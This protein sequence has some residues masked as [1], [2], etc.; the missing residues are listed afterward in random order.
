M[1]F[2]PDGEVINYDR[3][4]NERSHATFTLNNGVILYV[5]NRGK[6]RWKVLDFTGD[7]LHVDHRGAEM[8]FERR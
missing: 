6:Q 5:D 1:E 4:G 3:S 2:L 7:R 8:F